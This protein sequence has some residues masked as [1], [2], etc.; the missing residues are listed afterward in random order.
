MVTLWACNS[1]SRS[2][3]ESVWSGRAR[4]HCPWRGMSLAQAIQRG[5]AGPPSGAATTS[6][7]LRPQLLHVSGLDD[8]STYSANNTASRPGKKSSKLNVAVRASGLRRKMLQVTT[9]QP[10]KGTAPRR[11]PCVQACTKYSPLPAGTLCNPRP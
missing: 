1:S 2:R 6:G 7:G 3:P 5:T 9:L 11:H 4:I 8:C 10:C